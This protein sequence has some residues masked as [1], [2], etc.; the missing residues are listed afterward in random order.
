M[1]G[2]EIPESF[3]VKLL[4]ALFGLVLNSEE[5][6]REFAAMIL[7]R[8]YGEAELTKQQPLRVTDEGKNWFVMGSYQ[9]PGRL[10][11]YGAWYIRFRKSDC[12]IETFAHYGPL[13]VP[14]EVKPYVIAAREA[15]AKEKK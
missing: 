2:D 5:I 15:K 10:P 3:D 8:L 1:S 14:D 13:E 7:K 12:R 6:A 9:E 11:D 4:K